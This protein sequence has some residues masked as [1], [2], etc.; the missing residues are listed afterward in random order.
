MSVFYG[1]FNPTCFGK[2]FFMQHT[3]DYISPNL[4]PIFIDEAFPNMISIDRD[5]C[6]WKYI[7][8]NI[9]HIFYSDKRYPCVGFLNRD[10]ATILY[11]NA[12]QFKNKNALEIGCWMGWSACHLY[13]AGVELDVIDPV[14]QKTEFLDSIVSS[15]KVC[16][17][18]LKNPNKVTLNA[19]S[20]PEVVTK[21]ATE[22]QKKWAFIFIDGHHGKQ[23]PLQDAMICEQFAEND[24]MIFFHDLI[25]PDVA[26]GLAYLRE[27]GWN[28]AIYHTAQ[29]MG[30][31]WRGNVTP[32]AHLPDPFFKWDIPEHLTS[33]SAASL[34]KAQKDATSLSQQSSLVEQNMFFN[35]ETL[36]TI[37]NAPTTELCK[38]FLSF[39][40]DK[41]DT[42]NYSK[43][44]FELF[45]DL[46]DKP[47]NILEF[48]I[49]SVDG[50]VRSN[51]TF[52]AGYKPGA[53]L[54]GWKAFFP[55]AHIYGCDVDPKI[56]FKEERLL[57]EV[58]D[59]TRPERVIELMYNK[60]RHIEFDIILDDSLHHPPSNYN[61]MKWMLPKIR[62]N[63]FYIIED[64]PNQ[65]LFVQEQYKTDPFFQEIAQNFKYQYLS[66][67]LPGGR[68]SND[69][70]LFVMQKL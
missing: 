44:Y 9:H 45:K 11:N 60:W 50:T 22:Q 55:Y 59:I 14:I 53:S 30:V 58:L 57:T 12:L 42:H 13:A 27:R 2:V 36:L 29:I 64:I 32:V 46:Q 26:E 39:G 69:N 24:A 51:M 23:H 3:S 20:S 1:A 47:I 62:P 41:V 38:A 15:L 65:N 66:L 33:F 19:G 16:R 17:P 67:P 4:Q 35:N 48:G 8:R 21:I 5:K 10:E 18:I 52:R 6:S 63:G 40:S 68:K 34:P 70:N 43:V 7:R 54:R 31:A 56:M 25:S 49:G 28:T 61:L 37:L